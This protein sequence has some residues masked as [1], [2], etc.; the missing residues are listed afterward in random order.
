MFSE[1][2]NATESSVWF[3][4]LLQYS[5]C[6]TKRKSRYNKKEAESKTIFQIL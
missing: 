5:R 6:R 4:N 2:E 1:N 3:E